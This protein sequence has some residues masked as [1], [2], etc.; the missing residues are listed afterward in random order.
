M[1]DKREIALIIG[2][3]IERIL[4]AEDTHCLLGRFGTH[5]PSG[6]A[7][8]LSP[9]DAQEQGVSRIHAQIHVADERL[10]VTDLDST[11]GTFIGSEK[12]MAHR[13]TELHNN[14]LLTLGRLAVKVV[15]R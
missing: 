2:D 13:P 11:N 8:D 1:A 4:L 6:Q 10:Y 14:D 9:H 5:R 15:F 3:H 7:I 12:L